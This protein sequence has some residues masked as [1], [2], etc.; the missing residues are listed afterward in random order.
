M[1]KNISNLRVKKIS[2]VTGP[3]EK[4]REIFPEISSCQDGLFIKT[5][6]FK[7]SP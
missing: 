4:V 5:R 1:K 2:V 6:A 7:L 3:V